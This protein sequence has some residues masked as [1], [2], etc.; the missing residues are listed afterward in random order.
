MKSEELFMKEFYDA[1]RKESAAG[2]LAK[3]QRKFKSHG[4]NPDTW[5]GYALYGYS[6]MNQEEEK[7]YAS[8]KVADIMNAAI[9]AY[10]KDEWETAIKKFE[11]GLLFLKTIGAKENLGSIYQALA[12]ASANSG[13]YA[14]GASYQEEFIKA[15]AGKLSKPELAEGHKTLGILYSKAGDNKK[16][17]SAIIEALMLWKELGNKKSLSEGYRTLAL[18]QE[19]G[20][21]YQDSLASFSAALNIGREVADKASVGQDLWDI[22]RIYYL[23]L[24]KFEESLKAYKEAMSIFRE[25]GDREKTAKL[26]LDIGLVYEQEGEYE[27]AKTNYLEGIR[28]SAEVNDK[29]AYSRGNLYLANVAWHTGDYQEAFK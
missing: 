25:I 8:Q 13:E 19:K 7:K 6:G 28:I 14:K 17:E 12:K 9:E 15:G 4:M 23:R 29:S 22:G 27:D 1:F 2:A 16:A 26:F 11:E 21:N 3:A 20:G 18:M 24:S 10:S 5:A